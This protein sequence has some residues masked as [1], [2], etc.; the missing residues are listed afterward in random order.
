M[1]KQYTNPT[2]KPAG[3]TTVG[4]RIDRMLD[5][6]SFLEDRIART[7]EVLFDILANH[8]ELQ[9]EVTAAMLVLNETRIDSDAR[10]YPEDET[11]VL[12]STGTNTKED[13]S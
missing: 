1:S 11:P 13:H 7:T 9:Y 12:V 2:L 3:Q 6:I 4:V 5:H 10:R 8:P